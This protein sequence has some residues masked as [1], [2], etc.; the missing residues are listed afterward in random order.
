MI[1]IHLWVILCLIKNLLVMIEDLPP[2]KISQIESIRLTLSIHHSKDDL[3]KRWKE[4]SPE[5]RKSIRE[6]WGDYL[7]DSYPFETGSEGHFIFAD[8]FNSI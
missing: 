4:L 5:I 3:K 7:N 1:F 8:F 6:E 2:R